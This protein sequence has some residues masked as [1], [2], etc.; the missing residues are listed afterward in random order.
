MTESLALLDADPRVT[1]TRDVLRYGDTDAN[2]HIN[3]ST[4]SVLCESGRVTLFRERVTPHLPPD[5]FVVIVR[6]VIE[7]KAELFYPGEVRTATWVSAVGRTSMTVKQAL[8]SGETLAATGEGVCVIMDGAS[9]RPLPLPPA[10]REALAG[11]M[12]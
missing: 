3:N 1:W 9:R 7:Y 2:G 6:L 11:A 4:F 8:F 12:R 5:A 10:A